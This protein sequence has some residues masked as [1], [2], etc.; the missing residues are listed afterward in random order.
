M[1]PVWLAAVGDVT[2]PATSSGTPYYCLQAGLAAGVFTGGLKLKTSD[3]I[4]TRRRILWNIWQILSKAQ[5][6]GYQYS[7][8][9]L[10]RLWQ[11]TDEKDRYGCLLNFFQLFPEAIMRCPA[12]ARW[13][14]I[15]QT[16][17]QL[18]Q[19][20]GFAAIVSES[21]RRDAIIREQAQYAAA[22]GVICHSDWTAQSVREAYA[23]NDNK[24]HVVICGANIDIAA[25]DNWENETPYRRPHH[26]GPLRAVF[27]G[28]E[29]KRK[30]LDRLLRAMRIARERGAAVTL[31]VLGLDPTALPTDL[32]RTPGVK[33]GGFVDK[34]KDPG[35]FI[36][37]LSGCDVGC[38]LSRA[39][40]GGIS[41]REFCR[42][43]LPTIAPDTGGSPEFVVPDATHLVSP[44]APDEAI[45]DILIALATNPDLLE[46]QREAAWAARR[47]A[48]WDRAVTRLAQVV[49]E[50][51]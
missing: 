23:I 19:Y 38:L 27:V 41:L 2:D 33:W 26:E 31:L 24:I 37:L 44:V 21:V 3:H 14:Y 48:G 4:W 1:S 13:F 45:A 6:G 29:W 42:L 7:E 8:T 51:A 35:R 32:A 25:L 15:D 40:A 47:D 10:D 39:E 22:E 28:K 43:G 16:L 34:R 18:F 50:A 49:N 5:R 20:Y 9:F 17:E 11:Q 36:E 30:G 46:R 12:L